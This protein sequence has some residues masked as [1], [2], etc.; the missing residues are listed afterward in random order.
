MSRY[1]ILT[2]SAFILLL[3]YLDWNSG[4][5]PNL[6]NPSNCPPG[7]FNPLQSC[8]TTISKCL[9]NV[10][11]SLLTQLF[12]SYIHHFFPFHP[13]P[14]IDPFHWWRTENNGQLATLCKPG[15]ILFYQIFFFL[16]RLALN[17]KNKISTTNFDKNPI[18]CFS[19]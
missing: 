19:N 4:V 1:E 6:K 3:P 2:V 5:G 18:S 14:V 17:D 15:L 8:L 12:P 16:F 7:L 9:P 10:G 11:L 13:S